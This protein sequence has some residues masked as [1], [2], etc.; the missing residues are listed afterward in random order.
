MPTYGDEMPIQR[1]PSG[2]P[3][4]GGTGSRS[5]SPGGARRW[6]P[7]RVSLLDDDLELPDRC[8]VRRLPGRHAEHPPK[9]RAVV[10]EQLLRVA[11][12]HDRPVEVRLCHLCGKLP[13][14]QRQRF[15]TVGAQR[16][17]Q[18]PYGQ[19]SH[20]PAPRRGGDDHGR[21]P[22]ESDAGVDGLAPKAALEPI[23]SVR[24]PRLPDLH[25]Q[26]HH[27]VRST[28]A[29][30]AVDGLAHLSGGAELGRADRDRQRRRDDEREL[31]REPLARRSSAPP[32]ASAR[33]RACRRP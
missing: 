13:E 16:E 27:D 24:E 33:R 21:E 11:P 4:P 10:E 8:R 25:G 1:V 20:Q 18:L 31:A 12:D 9:L 30:S 22:L 32:P 23:D 19:V 29:R 3:G 7:P 14:R 6:V 15:A 28:H 2:L 5:F 17:P 26:R